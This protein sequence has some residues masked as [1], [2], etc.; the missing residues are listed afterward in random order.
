MK[1]S[2]K[3]AGKKKEKMMNNIAILGTSD[4]SE[5]KHQ[6]PCNDHKLDE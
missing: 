5:L 2:R 6:D 1:K 3:Q 4:Q